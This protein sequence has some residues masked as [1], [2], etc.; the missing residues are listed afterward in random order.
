MNWVEEKVGN[1]HELIDT[2]KDFLNRTP[3]AQAPKSTIINENS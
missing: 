3:Q 2:G 1:G